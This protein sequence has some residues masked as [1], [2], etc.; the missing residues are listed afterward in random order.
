[1]NEM[2]LK[3]ELEESRKLLQVLQEELN[4]TNSELL[5]LT[6]NLE[7]R[8]TELKHAYERLKEV[9]RLKNMFISVMSHE[10]RTPL[11][12]IIGFSSIMLDE[13]IGPLN[14]EQKKNLSTVHRSGQHLLALINDVIDISKI[15]AG[16]VTPNLDE[17]DL[18]DVISEAVN[19][20]LPQIKDKGL[21]IAV[22]TIHQPMRTDRRRLL[23]SLLNLMS[24]AVKFTERGRIFVGAGLAPVL[25]GQP[26][27][28]P[29]QDFVEISISDTGIG[30]KEEDIS[31][32]FQSFIRI[33]SPLRSKVGG[34]GLGL[35]LTKKLIT[36]VLKGEISVSSRYGEGSRFVMRIPGRPQ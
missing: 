31:K 13:W 24:N 7:D 19:S 15:E 9:D 18:H 14:E 2:E 33:D 10:L 8:A 28:L 25:N 21:E 27:G 11:N 30:I 1:M 3:Q 22:E 17:F 12:S 26:Q 23:Q 32:L 4:R 34:T 6:L 35:Y 36:E 29:L 5:Q 20:I 16:T